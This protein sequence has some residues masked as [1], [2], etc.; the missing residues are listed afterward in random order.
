M[1]LDPGE[2]MVLQ[3]QKLFL[4]ILVFWMDAAEGQNPPIPVLLRKTVDTVELL[5]IGHDRKGD[6]ALQSGFLCGSGKPLRRSVG[7]GNGFA[8]FP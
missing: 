6:R 8:P 5:R 2:P 1:K 7:K 4:I 3:I